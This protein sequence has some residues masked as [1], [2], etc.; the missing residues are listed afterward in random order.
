MRYELSTETDKT[1]PLAVL[2]EA[3]AENGYGARVLEAIV[4]SL[5]EQLVEE[6]CGKKHARGNGDNRYRRAGTTTRSAVTIVGD[7]EFTLHYVEDTTAGVDEQSYFRP[8]EDVIEFDGQ[9]IYQE[10]ISAQAVELATT[11]SYR[12]AVADGDGF[13]SMP[14]KATINRRVAEYGTKLTEFL[15]ERLTETEAETVIPDRTQCPSQ[16]DNGDH[17]SVSVTLAERDANEKTLLDVSVNDTWKDIVTGLDET[18]VIAEQA[19]IVSDAGEKLVEAFVDD[20]RIHQLDLLHLSRTTKYYL[21]KDDQ[22][23][24]EE[25]TEYV[26][27]VKDIAFHLK[28]SVAKHNPQ[29]EYWAICYRIERTREQLEQIAAELA[30][31]DC[32]NTAGYLRRWTSSVVTF[33]QQALDEVEVP[34]T[35]NLVERAMGT[36]A[37]RC[38]QQWMRWT[39]QGLESI[40]TLI[41]VNDANPDLYETF[42][43]KMVGRS[44][45]T[46]INCEVSSGT[47]RGRL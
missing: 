6:Y 28:N 10:D 44:T 14:S 16:D 25:R 26:E 42:I 22:F 11:S 8:I 1:V 7:H 39:E 18:D 34:W 4:E 3:V 29:R 23:P 24:L 21:W 35:S 13:L 38:K 20:E 45:K 43:D 5:D 31:N 37:D 32:H 19:A 2:G 47:T 40:L 27:K 17:H 15:H 30:D 33:A 12:D 36:V 41:L 46:T 9:R